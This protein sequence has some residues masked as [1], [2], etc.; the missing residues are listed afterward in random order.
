M[1][2]R[3][4]SCQQQFA[5]AHRRSLFGYLK[6]PLK[7]EIFCNLRYTSSAYAKLFT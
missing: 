3:T 5:A 7:K 1:P 2:E 6:S 4:P